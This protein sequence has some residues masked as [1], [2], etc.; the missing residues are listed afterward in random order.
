LTQ[1]LIQWTEPEFRRQVIPPENLRELERHL[2]DAGLIDEDGN[3]T[4]E[5]GG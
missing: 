1:D 2:R 3:L 5:S 4:N